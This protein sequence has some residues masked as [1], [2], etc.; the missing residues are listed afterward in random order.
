MVRKGLQP[1]SCRARVMSAQQAAK[2]P[3]RRGPTLQ[4]TETPVARSKVSMSSR[5]LTGRPAP[6]LQVSTPDGRRSS[7]SSAAT[8]PC[9][10]SQTCT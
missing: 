9:A 6:R 5:T 2:S 1:S 4:G 7:A 10:M 8:C 3:S